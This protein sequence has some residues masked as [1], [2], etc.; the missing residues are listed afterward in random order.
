MVA[1]V[2]VMCLYKKR[3]SQPLESPGKANMAMPSAVIARDSSENLVNARLLH[4][5][6]SFLVIVFQRSFAFAELSQLFCENACTV[7]D[8]RVHDTSILTHINRLKLKKIIRTG[9]LHVVF[10]IQPSFILNELKVHCNGD[11]G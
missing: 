4:F 5:F 3:R 7:G 9:L 8:L 11:K 10:F 2:V 6:V 1:F